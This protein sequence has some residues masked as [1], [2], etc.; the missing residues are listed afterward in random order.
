L[1]VL[2]VDH[3]E[4]RIGLAISDTTG[5][6]ARPLQVILHVSRDADVQRVAE[7]ARENDA[8]R[9]LVGYSMDEE[10]A[11]K[12]AGQRAKRFADALRA[13]VTIPVELWDESMSTQDARSAQLAAGVSRRRRRAAVDALAASFILQSYL[14]ARRLRPNEE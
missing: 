13:R 3:G 6:L 5:V 7:L 9:I 10:G 11:P 1:R 2:A 14:D 12:P 4:K 8:V